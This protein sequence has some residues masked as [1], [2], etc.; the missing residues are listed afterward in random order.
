MVAIMRI[1]VFLGYFQKIFKFIITFEDHRLKTTNFSIARKVIL[2]GS[3]QPLLQKTKI[4]V[5]DV[6]TLFRFYFIDRII[7]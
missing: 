3:E 5:H 6:L 1:G 7:A 2:S 4:L